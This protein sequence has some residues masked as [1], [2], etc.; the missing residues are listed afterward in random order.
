MQYTLSSI[1]PIIRVLQHVLPN[2]MLR[3]VCLYIYIHI[4]IYIYIHIN[5]HI[6]KQIIYNFIPLVYIDDLMI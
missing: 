4:Y 1:F 6:Y 5:I 3:H 2:H